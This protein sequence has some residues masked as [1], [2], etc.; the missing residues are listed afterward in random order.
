MDHE[1][2]AAKAAYLADARRLQQGQPPQ[3]PAFYSPEM[4]AA[5][6]ARDIVKVEAQSTGDARSM[7]DTDYATARAALLKSTR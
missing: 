3:D 4:R 1:Y 2:E 6:I 7:S 5:F